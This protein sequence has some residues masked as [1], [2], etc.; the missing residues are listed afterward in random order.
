MSG[1]E[2]SSVSY[3][4]SSRF[5]LQNASYKFIHTRDFIV[6]VCVER[7][8]LLPQLHCAVCT[9]LVLPDKA[10][11]TAL[12]APPRYAHA[13]Y[14][15][16]H[17]IN[18]SEQIRLLS[19]PSKQRFRRIGVGPGTLL[20]FWPWRPLRVRVSGIKDLRLG[21]LAYYFGV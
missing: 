7:I 17:Q 18:W 6:E 15:A 20:N 12:L 1:R 14:V 11:L 19:S 3:V 8:S 21:W 13:C 5:L 10:D 9:S 4:F 16:L 2:F